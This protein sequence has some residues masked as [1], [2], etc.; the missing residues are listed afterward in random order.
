MSSVRRTEVR[1]ARATEGALKVGEGSESKVGDDSE[2]KVEL[3]SK[4]K[5]EQVSELKVEVVSELK[6]EEVSELKDIVEPLELIRTRCCTV[7]K[8]F[9]MACI[10]FIYQEKSNLL[11][12]VSALTSIL[13]SLSSD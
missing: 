4:L 9:A 8:L 5:V 11:N 7:S 10:F 12:N 2:L 6:V 1:S 13:D 3:V